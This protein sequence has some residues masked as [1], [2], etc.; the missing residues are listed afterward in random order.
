MKW[1]V[2]VMTAPRTTPSLPTTIQSLQNCGWFPVVFA[3]PGSDLSGITAPVIQRP[4]K[5]GNFHN[6]L[7]MAR[8]LLSASD[9]DTFLLCEDDVELAIGSK[10]LV[11]SVLW[12]AKNC[13]SVSLFCPSARSYK[14]VTTP[15]FLPFN[16]CRFFCSLAMVFPRHVLQRMVD[17]RSIKTWKGSWSQRKQHRVPQNEIKAVDT[18]IALELKSMGL[19]IWTF[20]PSL[21]R[22]LEGPSSLGHGAIVGPRASLGWVG[23]NANLQEMFQ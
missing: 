1:A 21:G 19:E 10:E 12:P 7:T 4:E 15:S 17:S 14:N 9:A 11:E 16:R 5:L 23:H 20:I 2:G 3:E 13:G 18:W 8:D 6:W 22:H